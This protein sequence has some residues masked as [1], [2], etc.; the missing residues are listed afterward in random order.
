M[1]FYNFLNENKGH[2]FEVALAAAIQEAKP[3]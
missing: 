1:R 2:D 3:N